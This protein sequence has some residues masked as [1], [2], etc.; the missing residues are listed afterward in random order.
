MLEILA[1]QNLLHCQCGS[2]HLIG[3]QFVEKPASTTALEKAESSATATSQKLVLHD[4]ISVVAE[5]PDPRR[6][7]ED[8][9]SQAIQNEL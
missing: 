2:S 1:M 8:S 6:S 7:V 3:E 5:R 9:V 4:H